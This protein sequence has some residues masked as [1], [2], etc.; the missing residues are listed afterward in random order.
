MYVAQTNT[1]MSTAF[2]CHTNKCGRVMSHIQTS[3]MTAFA[4][5]PFNVVWHG[6]FICGTTCVM[7][8]AHVCDMTHSHVWFDSIHMCDMTRLHV[9]HVLMTSWDFW[10]GYVWYDSIRMCDTPRKASIW[11]HSYV[12]HDTPRK[13]IRMCDMTAFICVAKHVKH[14]HVWHESI[15]MCDTT[16]LVKHWYVWHDSIHMCDMP[17]KAFISVTWKHSYVWR[18]S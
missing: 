11:K 10:D 4:C 14:P 3:D 9:W 12:W 15:H 1:V 16:H 2:V 18:V 7:W 6:L 5:V 13:S 17:C 8:L